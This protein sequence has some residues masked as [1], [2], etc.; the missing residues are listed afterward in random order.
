MLLLLDSVVLKPGPAPCSSLHWGFLI[1][2]RQ[3][4]A[5]GWLISFVPWA[6]FLCAPGVGWG[7]RG[8]KE[9]GFTCPRCPCIQLLCPGSANGCCSPTWHFKMARLHILATALPAPCCTLLPK[10]EGCGSIPP[11]LPACLQE[12]PLR[13]DWEGLQEE[14]RLQLQL[15][16]SLPLQEAHDFLSRPQWH[17]CHSTSER[18]YGTPGCHN[19]TIEHHSSSHL[20]FISSLSK[21]PL[22]VHR[23][24][25]F[26]DLEKY[27]QRSH[28]KS[29]AKPRTKSRPPES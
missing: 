14:L 5:E 25:S 23:F 21:H 6:K 27:S 20:D 4:G 12:E 10:T 24:T 16:L 15:V 22:N 17:S 3:A 18:A 8:R 11:V 2:L 9:G 28:M 29:V 19:T 26:C 13:S 7:G 1:N